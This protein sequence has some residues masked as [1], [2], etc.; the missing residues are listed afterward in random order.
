MDRE[1]VIWVD[2]DGHELNL[3]DWVN[4]FCPRDRSGIWAPPYTI[5]STKMP[6]SEGS[7]FRSVAVG[8]G[9]VDL[10]LK[11]RASDNNALHLILRDLTNRMDPTRGKGQLK[12][13]TD[14][15]TRILYCLPEGL[16]K[17]TENDRFAET[18]L[19]FTANDP[20][21]YS[22]AEV[23]TQ[24]ENSNT[25]IYNFFSTSFFPI[26]LIKSTTYALRTVVNQGDKDVYPIWTITG[27]GNTIILRNLT[28]GKTLSLG[29]LSLAVGQKLEIDTRVGIKTVKV[30]GD[31]GN[32]E[33]F[34][35]LSKTSSFWSLKKGNNDLSLQMTN[36]NLNSKIRITFT[37]R[38][39]SA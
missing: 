16:K 33:Y 10:P 13:I 25:V 17:V 23:I 15:D 20:Y 21:W 8:E 11:I 19:S 34:S 6:L 2:V 36:S 29:S 30:D 37:P 18:T 28:T 4:Y 38:Y 39:G 14:L 31:F 3:N 7:Q 35:F 1:Q 32:P 12:I 26:R 9:G 27:P 5:N 24:I 22:D